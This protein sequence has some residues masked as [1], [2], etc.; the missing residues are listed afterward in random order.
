MRDEFKKDCPQYLRD[1]LT[2]VRVIRN[3]TVLTE[4]QYYIDLRTFL[5]WL[6]I[7][8]GDV[9]ADTPFEDITIADVPLSYIENFSLMSAYEYMS[10]LMDERG[11]SN[12]SR[13]RKTSSLRQ[14]YEYLSTK[15][16]VISKNPVERLEHPK[17]QQKLPKYLELEQSEKLLSSIESKNQQ[18]DYCIIT[19]LLN[20]GLRL[21]ELVGLNIGDYS[22]N[23][24]TLRVFGKGQK[25]R[26][27]YLND[28]C[29]A[30]IKDYLKVRP[31]SPVEPN[32]LFISSHANNL[33]RLSNRRVQRIVEDQLKRA[34][35]SNMGISTHKLRHTAATLLYEYGH[36]DLMV[37][38]EVLGHV[39]IGTTQIYTHLS[40]RD[41]RRAAESSPLKDI[42]NSSATYVRD[43]ENDADVDADD[44]T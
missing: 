1:Y 12:A 20:C 38:K 24:R 22:E 40:D 34:G 13:S 32:A 30:A 2:Y 28:A 27:L 8:N 26:I 4:E 39:N 16:M 7:R 35:L 29:I 36:V 3:H 21:S 6:K 43:G 44:N 37:L 11:N 19:L 25:E 41:R 5:R 33:T 9:S 31:K 10:F 18:R 17:P 42:R 23:A 14:F 15:A